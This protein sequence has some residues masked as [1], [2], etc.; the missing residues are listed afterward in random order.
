[1][2]DGIDACQEIG[3]SEDERSHTGTVER[4]VRAIDL[5]A[6]Q[7]RQPTTDGGRCDK[8]A[9][10]FTVSVVNRHAIDPEQGG[11]HRLAT[12]DAARDTNRRHVQSIYQ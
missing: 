9:L 6:E 10:A 8:E 11:D 7:G 3:V 12:T 4:G 2:D 1:M 5:G